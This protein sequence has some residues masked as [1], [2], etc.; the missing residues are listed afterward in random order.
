MLQR[1]LENMPES[2]EHES[3]LRRIVSGVR[4]AWLIAS[5]SIVLF[6]LAVTFI[7]RHNREIGNSD[8]SIVMTR[9]SGAMEKP[10]LGRVPVLLVLPF[11]SDDDLGQ[12]SAA[13][14]VTDGIARSLTRQADFNVRRA[15]SVNGT[16]SS[17]LKINPTVDYV[18]S[19]SVRKID[20]RLRI[21]VQLT[22]VG[23]QASIWSRSYDHDLNSDGIEREDDIA[24]SIVT[25]LAKLPIRITPVER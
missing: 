22:N 23:A 9:A 14:R 25:E 4:P 15:A 18:V 6:S 8:A 3:F 1:L 2:R 10:D 13:A 11:H 24:R 12:P 19:G 7:D 21:F 16:A 17:H 20:N 5:L